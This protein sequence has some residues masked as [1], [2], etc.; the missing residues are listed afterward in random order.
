M[1]Y[2]KDK[3][4]LQEVT[5]L[6]VMSMFKVST[7]RKALK[8]PAT[9]SKSKFSICNSSVRYLHFNS[10]TGNPLNCNMHGTWC[11]N[12]SETSEN[13]ES[14]N[15][16]KKDTS[17]QRDN[18]VTSLTVQ[19]L[20]T[21]SNNNIC[22]YLFLD[23]SFASMIKEI[24]NLKMLTK[25]LYIKTQLSTSFSNYASCFSEIHPKGSQL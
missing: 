22:K 7:W 3:K 12:P 19:T 14:N 9:P 10:G 17:T 16:K 21:L 24:P 4:K 25:G 23:K 11:N 20:N 13:G 15:Q 8:R 2:I 18:V 5:W 6:S 1:S